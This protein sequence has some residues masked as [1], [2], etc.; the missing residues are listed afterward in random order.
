MRRVAGYGLYVVVM[1]GF[2]ELASRLMLAIP[3]IADRRAF[4]DELSWRR[5]WVRR[6]P[7]GHEIRY[8]FDVYDPATGWRVKPNLRDAPAFGD[9]VLNTNARGL[10]GRTDHPY[11]KS[12]AHPRILILGDSFTFGEGVGDTET[13][14]AS[15]QAMMPHAEVLNMGVHGYGH[16]QMLILLREE[17]VKYAPDLIIL[18]FVAKDMERNLVGFR[19]YAKPKF[20]IERGALTLTDSPVPPPEEILRRD[21]ARPRLYDIWSITVHEFRK[22]TGLQQ[23]AAERL[24]ALILADMIAVAERIHARPLFVY[25]P[26]GEEIADRTPLTDGERF[27][28]GV[29]RTYGKVRCFSTRP[30]FA[31]EMARG[32]TFKL[33]GHWDPAGH[34]VVAKAIRRYLMGEGVWECPAALEACAI[35]TPHRGP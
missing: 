35:A 3:Y 11:G 7:Q 26:V 2:F 15:L 19:D 21:W 20:V 32:T 5:S 16:D 18:G 33:T 17:G 9:K 10:R 27:L 24:T 6:H 1:L 34:R 29:C 22:W 28:S 23:R 31:E 8:D 13:Y 4:H 30:F 25:L 12:A 14:A